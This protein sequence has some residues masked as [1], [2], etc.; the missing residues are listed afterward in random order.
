M[1]HI[2]LIRTDV[3]DGTLQVLDL[4]PNTSQRS[5]IY[6]PGDGQTKYINRVQNDTVATAAPGAVV[7]VAEYK[8]VAAW[9]IDS[10]EDTPNGDALTA[11]QANTIAA[12][13][14]ARLDTGVSMSVSD[15]NS[16]IAATVTG[17]GI[18][19]GSS[20]GT[21]AQLLSILAGAEYV[22]PAGSTVDDDGST[23]TTGQAGAFTSGQAKTTYNTGA[24]KISVGEGYLSELKAATFSYAGTAGAAVSV[25]DDDGSLL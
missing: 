21:L 20:D 7:T 12:A 25:L 16:V 13:L 19:V 4:K 18:G 24:F 3:P 15:V 14:I 17:A 23:Y 1:P 22:L 9:L 10:I 2:C 11:A 5:L 6:D 8:G